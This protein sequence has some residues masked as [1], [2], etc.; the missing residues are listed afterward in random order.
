[1]ARIVTRSPALLAVLFASTLAVSSAN[2][3]GNADVKQW[4]VVSPHRP[5][6]RA[7]QAAGGR[8]P[9]AVAEHR[10]AAHFSPE[11]HAAEVT[12]FGLLQFHPGGPEPW[13]DCG[14]AQCGPACD[15]CDGCCPP[16]FRRPPPTGFWLSGEYLRWTIS[17]AELPPLVRASPA[18]TPPEQ[19]GVVG[20]T[21]FG[22]DSPSHTQSGARIAG[23]WWLDPCRHSGFEF[24]YAFLPRSS[25]VHR[26]DSLDFPRLGRPYFDTQAGS[27]AA[28]LVS[29]PDYLA[30]N[31]AVTRSSELHVADF[32]RRT[33]HFERPCGRVDTLFGLRFASL[34]DDLL[35]E[36][37]SRYTTGIG[38]I[39]SGTQIDLFDRFDTQSQFFG[40][41]CGVD[42]HEQIGYWNVNVRTSLGL[43]NTHARLDVDGRTVTSVPGAGSSAFDG[44]LLAQSTNIRSVTQNRF[45]AMPEL[46]AGVSTRLNPC[47]ELR[48]GYHLLYWTQAVQA[49]DQIDRRLSQLPPEPAVG[50]GGPAPRFDT[51][52]VLIQGLQTGLM[53]RF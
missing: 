7:P 25:H 35:I 42:Y 3:Q 15:S 45:T 34:N 32:L 16:A 17:G 6:G 22:G 2:G 43:G 30:G 11:E 40:V 20:A 26:F 8:S 28:M 41:V 51:R 31:V 39:I 36:Q 29:H 4:R 9:A 50:L 47:W 37:S 13:G 38:Q 46:Y 44:G 23:G 12:D 33:L 27:E 10:Q 24:A 48:L 21:L 53:C 49:G 14:I 1:M 19:T 5:A 18:A 52:G